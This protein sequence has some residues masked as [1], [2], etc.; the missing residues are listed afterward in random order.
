[1]V[2]RDFDL[3]GMSVDPVKTESKLIV[4]P[5][6]VLPFSISAKPFEPVSRRYGKLSQ[7]SNTIELIHFPL[8][9]AP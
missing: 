5:H 8:R 2:I 1:M 3:V 7:I 9:D 6:A 4:D